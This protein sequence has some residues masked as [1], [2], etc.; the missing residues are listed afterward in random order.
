MTEPAFVKRR[1]AARPGSIPAVLQMFPREVRF[2]REVA[3]YVGVRVPDCYL[4]EEHRG[5]THLELEDLSDWRE[6]ADPEAAA[7]LLAGLHTRWEG[8]AVGRWPWLGRADVSDLV[9]RLYDETWASARDRTEVT[10][11]VRDLGDSLVGRVVEADQRAETAG[12]P[13]LVH[14]D[15]SAANLRTSATGEIALLDWE[16]YG[17][18]P[19]IGDLAWHLVSSVGP[20]DWGRAVTAYGDASGLGEALPSA[21]VQGLLSFAFGASGDDEGVAWVARLEEA[22]RRC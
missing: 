9:E 14:G 4:A 13:T 3:P 19:G 12:P 6:G 15:A 5:A 21:C 7:R 11:T 8:T 1:A 20:A 2:Y 22:A 16:D 10:A 18:G 17:S